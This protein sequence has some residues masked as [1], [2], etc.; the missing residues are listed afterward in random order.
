MRSSEIYQ[1]YINYFKNRGHKE[2]ANSSLR[3]ENDS[4]LLFVNSGM[5]PL[6]PYLLGEKHPLGTRLVN[7]QR[8]I[9]TEDIEEVWDATH[10]TFFQMAGNW[11]L[12]DYFKNEQLE[13]IFDFLVNELMLDPKKIRVTVH[14]WERSYG[15]WADHDAVKI[16]QEQFA[17]VWIDAGAVDL[18]EEFDI[19]DLEWKYIFYCDSKENRW[20]RAWVPWNMPVWEPWWPD[21]EIYYEFDEDF[22]HPVY[23]KNFHPDNGRFVEIWNNVFM[24]YKKEKDGGFSELPNKNIDFGWWF[25]RWA[26]IAQW[27]KSVFE[28]DLFSSINDKIRNLAWLKE[29]NKN[30]YVI[31]D[32]VRAV[33][34]CIADGVNPSN[35][36]AGYIVRRLARRAIKFG[37]ELGI[38]WNFL[39]DIAREVIDSYKDMYP[40]LYENDGLILEAIQAE[41]NQFRQTLDRGIREFEKI[42]SGWIISWKD[43][44]ILFTTYGFPVEM[45]QEMVREKGMIFDMK[46]YEEEMK[47]HQEL[48][49]TS[50]AGKFKWWLADSSEATTKLHTA[51]HLMLQALRMVL[52][53][54]VYQKWSNITAERLRFDFSHPDKMTQEQKDEV[55]KIVNEAIQAQLPV[56]CEEMSLDEARNLWAIWVFDDK[57]GER[58]KVY[59]MWEKWKEFSKELCGG[60]HVENTRWMWVFKIKKE[61]ASSAGVRRIK[62]V[63]E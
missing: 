50:S 25:E 41:E 37:L 34:F 60:P 26:M 16:R 2:I 23:G 19:S 49:R 7:I 8:C 62:G 45:T 40:Y 20:S 22:V 43:A 30:V 48:S 57:Y 6:V 31:S 47:K 36:E 44:F 56:Y 35:V 10:C 28:T 15:I 38:Q 51:C 27:K 42:V 5:F 14:A 52:W 12:G 63:L 21:S 53:D 4:T 29:N 3:P 17:K 46:E 32:H 9:R 1:K 55:E 33:V 11:S 13:W 24:Q 61:E 39:E 58:V 18:T 59:F 54:H